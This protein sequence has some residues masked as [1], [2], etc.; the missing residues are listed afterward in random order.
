[1]YMSSTSVPQPSLAKDTYP[2]TSYA[3]SL[4]TAQGDIAEL[5]YDPLDEGDRIRRTIDRVR[6]DDAG[7]VAVFLGTTR[8]GFQGDY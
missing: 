3:A 4:T 6:R 8:D 5:T 2:P 7:A 1:M